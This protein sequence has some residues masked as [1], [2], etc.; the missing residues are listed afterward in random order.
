MS[1]VNTGASAIREYLENPE[2]KLAFVA[3]AEDPESPNPEFFLIVSGRDVIGKLTFDEAR[4]VADFFY[5]VL[6]P[7]KDVQ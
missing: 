3:A 2:G 6:P 7:R 5:T 1:N 4:S